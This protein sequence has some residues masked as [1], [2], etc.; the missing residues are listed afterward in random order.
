MA[1]LNKGLKIA[2]GIALVGITGATIFFVVKRI[3]EAR[4]KAKEKLDKSNNDADSG[5]Q[6]PQSSS[7]TQKPQSSTPSTTT[8]IP[9][10]NNTE[11]NLFRAWVND[12]Y[13]KYAKE[14]KL[15]R[16]GSYNNSYIQK[17][18]DKYG[19]Q[20]EAYKKKIRVNDWVKVTTR[21]KQTTYFGN[22]IAVSGQVNTGYSRGYDKSAP[23]NFKYKVRRISKDGATGEEMAYIF[24]N[25]DKSNGYTNG[26][27]FLV[28]TKYLQKTTF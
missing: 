13:P 18:Y 17:A 14:I 11:G 24:N 3:K 19:N 8:T 16:T 27:G 12:T 2:I 28:Y 4:S 1:N 7:G 5:T 20:Y 25:A 15:E 23:A 6:K 21:N 22:P 26:T 9:F 10:K